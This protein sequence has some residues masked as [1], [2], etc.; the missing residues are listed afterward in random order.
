MY[1]VKLKGHPIT[2]FKK[3]IVTSIL[4]GAQNGTIF[5]HLKFT[6]Y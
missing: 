4:Q 5:V 6:K 2:H 1:C 3:L